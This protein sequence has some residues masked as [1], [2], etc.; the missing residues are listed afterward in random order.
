MSP[1]IFQKVEI[2]ALVFLSL[3]FR[4][5]FLIVTYPS[6][7]IVPYFQPLFQNEW[8]MSGLWFLQS[9]F[10]VIGGTYEKLTCLFTAWIQST[11]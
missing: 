1:E 7:L 11:E 2:W 5:R 3:K 6:L 10:Q 9:L 4:R 8:L